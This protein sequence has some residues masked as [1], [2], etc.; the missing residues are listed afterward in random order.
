ME[1]IEEAPE[2]KKELTPIQTAIQ[3]AEIVE[4]MLKMIKRLKVDNGYRSI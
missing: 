4:F 1:K 2:E 3:K